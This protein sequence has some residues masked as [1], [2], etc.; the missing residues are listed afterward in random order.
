MTY[1]ETRRVVLS[2]RTACQKIHMRILP[3][4]QRDPQN[5]E[6]FGIKC[7]RPQPSES[8]CSTGSPPPERGMAPGG[9]G[10]LLDNE[11]LHFGTLLVGASRN[12]WLLVILA[13][14]LDCGIDHLPVIE[15]IYLE[16][17][18]KTFYKC[19]LDLCE[20]FVSICAKKFIWKILSIMCF[21]CS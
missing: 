17:H 12:S 9:P 11:V 2:Q 21:Y 15:K 13:E 7:I 3:Q 19:W 6:G 5:V 1:R 16:L 10:G 18:K 14:F 20:K 8:L 4:I